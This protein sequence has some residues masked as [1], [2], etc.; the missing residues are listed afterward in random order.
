MEWL[1]GIVIGSASCARPASN[2]PANPP[3]AASTA[4]SPTVS[5]PES[6][7]G[8]AP[9]PT[10]Q[11]DGV[12]FLIDGNPADE[13]TFERLVESTTEVPGTWY[14]DDLADGGETGWHGKDPDGTVYEIR[15]LS[16]ANG[17]VSSI[18]TLPP[19]P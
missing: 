14:C 16:D 2:P 11:P 8:P 9:E 15:Y 12:Q 13:E 18:R 4:P 1:L 10:T 19:E 17:S 7:P 3:T 6:T 5:P